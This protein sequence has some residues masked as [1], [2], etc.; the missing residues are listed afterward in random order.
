MR[1]L[2]DT[3]LARNYSGLRL[4]EREYNAGH[5]GMDLPFF[6]DSLQILLGV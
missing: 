3:V 5:V 2:Y 1:P 4:V 6:R